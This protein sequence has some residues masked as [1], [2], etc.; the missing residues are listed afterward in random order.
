MVRLAYVALFALSLPAV[1]WGKPPA[2]EQP[3][4]ALS[5]ALPR[6]S[7]LR[8]FIDDQPIGRTQIAPNAQFGFGTFGLKSERTHLQP[9]TAREISGPKQRRAAVG[10]LLKF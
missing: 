3:D 8:P 6:Q 2:S 7:S 5:Y 10:F 4:R 1:S 9:V